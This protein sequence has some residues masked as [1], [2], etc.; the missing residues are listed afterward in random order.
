MST[1]VAALKNAF[2]NGVSEL[3]YHNIVNCMR[4]Y[5]AGNQ[6]RIELND[7]EKKAVIAIGY[8]EHYNPFVHME[9]IR[10]GLVFGNSNP[11]IREILG[12]HYNDQL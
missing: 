8:P 7:D 6:G 9:N 4:E 5:V 2:D 12:S 11:H 10:F 3:D 1:I